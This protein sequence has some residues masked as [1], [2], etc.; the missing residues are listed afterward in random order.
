MKPGLLALSLYALT[1]AGCGGGAPKSSVD[2]AIAQQADTALRDQTVLDASLPSSD[3]SP[4]QSSKEPGLRSPASDVAS[5][6]DTTSGIVKSLGTAATSQLT[7]LPNSGGGKIALT[8]PDLAAL[9][10]TNGAEVWMTGTLRSGPG[11][12]LAARSMEVERFVVRAVDGVTVTDGMLVADGDAVVLVASD[13]KRHRLVT[14]PS[15][16]QS[17]VGARVWIAGRMDRE[18]ST[19]G[20]II[21]KS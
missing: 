15:A 3:S 6:N 9:G 8:G 5:R 13:G 21:P 4:L 1:Q 20:V 10:R 14:P 11:R 17:Q 16:L 7:L 12:P 18:P 19:F 2:S